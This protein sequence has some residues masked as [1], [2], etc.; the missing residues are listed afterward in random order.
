MSH[1]TKVKLQ[2]TDPGILQKA[3]T[4]MGVKSELGSFTITQYGTSSSAE[5]QCD[6]A[7][8]FAKQQDGTFARVGDFYHARTQKLKGYYN[9]LEKFQQ[10]L[11]VAYGIEDAIQK[12]DDLGMGFEIEENAE[13]VIGADG[14]IRL[15]A[16]SW[17]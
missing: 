7:V 2:V 14:M 5:V 11:N 13:G 9:N 17:S 8:G 12:L 3:L 16:V 1:W 10:E 6:E 4:Q 15:V